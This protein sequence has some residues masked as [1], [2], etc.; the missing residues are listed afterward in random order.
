MVIN[1]AVESEITL[2]VVLPLVIGL[3]IGII[4]AYFVYEDEN[5]TS[6]KQFLGDMWHGL[7]FSV[8]G[9]LIASN[10]PWLLTQDLIPEFIHGLLLLDEGTGNSLIISI[11]ITIFMMIKMVTSHA[12]KGVSGTGFKEKMWHKFVIAIAVGFAPYYMIPLYASGFMSGLQETIPWL[13]F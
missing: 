10:V 8:V 13:P 3:I 9:T 4:E 7:I 2:H 5:M 11:A 12:I 6:G 1:M